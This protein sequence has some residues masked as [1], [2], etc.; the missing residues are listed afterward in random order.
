MNKSRERDGA[1]V[2]VRVGADADDGV[3]AC[4]ALLAHRSMIVNGSR[5]NHA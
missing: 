5:L 3:R 2:S 4:V 1:W